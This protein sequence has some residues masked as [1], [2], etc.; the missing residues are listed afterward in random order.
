MQDILFPGFPKRSFSSQKAACVHHSLSSVL[1]SC[2]HSVLSPLLFLSS[3]IPSSHFLSALSSNFRNRDCSPRAIYILSSLTPPSSSYVPSPSLC[4]C[5]PSSSPPTGF[6]KRKFW[7]CWTAAAK[8]PGSG[9]QVKV[10]LRGPGVRDVS[11]SGLQDVGGSGSQGSF[12]SV[13]QS[14]SGCGLQ[15]SNCIGCERSGP[16]M[17]SRPTLSGCVSCCRP[18]MRPS[19]VSLQL[20]AATSL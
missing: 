5:S 17:W 19:P 6:E 18:S 11:G 7:C 1:L 16:G 8:V 14:N 15:S 4:Q 2:P 10:H 20:P 12:G 13:L 3:S 9:A